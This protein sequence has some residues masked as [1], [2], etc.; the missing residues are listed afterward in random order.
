MNYNIIFRYTLSYFDK[1]IMEQLPPEIITSICKILTLKERA[2][3]AQCC[4]YLYWCHKSN[5]YFFSECKKI[6]LQIVRQEKTLFTLLQRIMNQPTL[7]IEYYEIYCERLLSTHTIVEY[8]ILSCR[9][10]DTI[11]ANFFLQRLVDLKR[12]HVLDAFYQTLLG[13]NYNVC[14][15]LFSQF[16]LIKSYANHEE[17]LRCLLYNSNART[18]NLSILKWVV[19]NCGI[20]TSQI[21]FNTVFRNSI[22]DKNIETALWAIKSDPKII[23]S[24]NADQLFINICMGNNLPIAQYFCSSRPK[25]YLFCYQQGLVYYR[26]NTSE[27]DPKEY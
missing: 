6:W 21:N 5:D 20:N 26:I 8:F 11:S 10:G 2:E 25:R 1:F 4:K 13:N 3:L 14:V 9:F 15:W 12:E 16:P 19:E 22:D 24:K 27:Y 18:N 17:I 23:H 7:L